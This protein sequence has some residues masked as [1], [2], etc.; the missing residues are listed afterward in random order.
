MVL[1]GQEKSWSHGF[2]QQP[3]ALGLGSFCSS[4]VGKL[5]RGEGTAVKEEWRNGN[6]F[7]RV[8]SSCLLLRAPGQTCLM[9][10][11]EPAAQG[12]RRVN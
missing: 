10:T 3:G 12:A 2:K 11:N 8:P 6:I 9:C 5:R 4:Q 1:G 7:P